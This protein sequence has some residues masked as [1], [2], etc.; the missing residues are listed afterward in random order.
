MQ[1]AAAPSTSSAAWVSRRSTGI[2]SVARSFNAQSLAGCGGHRDV[3]A[4]ARCTYPLKHAVASAGVLG[5]GMEAG[6]GPAARILKRAAPGVRAQAAEGDVSGDVATKTANP[7]TTGMVLPA[8]GIACL[9]AIL[10]GYHLGVVNGA[11]DYISRDLGFATNTVKQGWVVSSTLAGATVGSFT[12]GALADKLGRK[13]TFQL[14]AL[15]LIVGTILSAKA[16]N[17]EAMVVGRI[18]VGVGI[19]VSSG[20]V[21]LYISE[22]SPT[23]IRGTMGTLN[24]LF[25]CIGI[26]LALIAGLPLGGNP[27]WWRTMFGMATV[28]A[29]L[30]ALGMTYCPESPR[31]LYKQGRI[32]DAE[33]AVRKLWGKSKVESSMAELK[34]GSIETVKGDNQDASWGELFG[35]RYR[36]VVTVGMAMFLFQQFA[37]INAVVYFSTQV[38]RSAGITSDVAASALVGAANVIGTTVAS[39]MMDKQG[40]RSLLMGSYAGMSLSMLV[41]SLALSWSALAPYSGTLAVLGTVAY[42]LAFSLGAGPVPALLLPEIFGARIRAKAVSVSLGVHWAC[43]FFIGLM[44]LS[45]V[46]RFGVSTVYLFFAAVCAAAVAYVNGNVVETKGRSL[47]DIERELSP[48]V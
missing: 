1:V 23:E 32:S 3:L 35:K 30:L 33:T 31:W 10:F 13:R 36:K 4:R 42:V 20:V 18:L 29:V 26:L 12:G 8:V 21:P 19:G 9:G 7:A 15:P 25:I 41:L 38:F 39:S 48:A 40:R 27:A 22:V 37:G 34:A 47:E 16:S 11:L 6:F 24:Q 14:N 46:Q 28:P 2:T 44:F 45:I 43:N 17:F 5:M